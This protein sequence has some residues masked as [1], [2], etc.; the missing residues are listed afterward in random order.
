M[1]FCNLYKGKKAEFITK[2]NVDLSVKKKPG[3]YI[4]LCLQIDVKYK[5]KRPLPDSLND[6]LNS[7]F[8]KSVN[9]RYM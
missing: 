7:I 4:I 2:K 5:K 8:H 9:K 6:F 1:Q 3:S